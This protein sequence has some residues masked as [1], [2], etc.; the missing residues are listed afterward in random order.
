MLVE[1]SFENF[2]SFPHEANFSMIAA[3]SVKEMEDDS[4]YSNVVTI[5]NAD[6][7]LLKVGAV[8]GANA[9]GKSNLIG[10][11]SFFKL[12]VLNSFLDETLLR[13]SGKAKF[14]LSTEG[15]NLPS[16]FEMTFI[17][18]DMRYR[19]GF[20]IK[21]EKV[22]SEWL[23]QKPLDAS[24]ESYCFTREN[25]E[26][27]INSKVF[28][29]AGRLQEKTRANALF[30]STSAQFNVETSMQIKEWFNT[31]LHILVAPEQPKQ[32][33][34]RKFMTD[35]WMKQRVL[36]FIKVIDLGIEDLS[37]TESS[38]DTNNEDPRLRQITAELA[39]MINPDGADIKKL[40]ILASHSVYD[41]D[42]L[43][44]KQVFPFE[45]ESLG[46]NKIFSLLG[47][48]FDCLRHGGTLV[49]DEFGAS[50]HTHLAMEMIRLFQSSMNGTGAQLIITTHDTNLLRK[51]LLRRDQIWFVEKNTKGESDLYSLVEYKIHQAQSVRNDASYQ[52]D[53]LVGKYGAIPYFGNIQQFIT[54]YSD[55]LQGEQN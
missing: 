1:F 6:L 10:A 17:I 2:M 23:F 35:E 42:N 14:L 30:L 52:K 15:H 41:G 50:L 55:G 36:N 4:E 11:L 5:N 9:S 29:G 3:N 26:I 25:G 22:D 51:D 43:V 28:K 44:S 27:K 21:N 38:I 37:V 46:T 24:R 39:R 7:R 13:D 32:F 40:D 48:W 20:E 54:D 53:Y 19:Y 45:L 49:V 34:A 33:T 47:P 12:M 8:Y 31:K 18:G 16:S